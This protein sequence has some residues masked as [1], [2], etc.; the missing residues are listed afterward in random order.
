MC[1]CSAVGG[2]PLQARR[3]RDRADVRVCRDG[4]GQDGEGGCVRQAPR[5]T[6]VTGPRRS[7]SLK[8]SDTRV[9][10]PQTRARLGT[11]A[12]FCK[13]VVLKL[14]AAGDGRAAVPGQR[15]HH[16]RLVQ[17]HFKGAQLLP[18]HSPVCA[19][20]CKAAWKRELRLPWREVGPPNHHDDKV[21]SDQ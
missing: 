13:V 2:A 14:R 15:I 20:R 1:R 19:A 21:D 10:E 5:G 4:V 16:F 7:L 6:L 8:W 9:Y 17:Q 3:L 11:T 12:Q 18:L